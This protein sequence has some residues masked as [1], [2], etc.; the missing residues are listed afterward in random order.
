MVSGN[1]TFSAENEILYNIP[2]P[3]NL[4][5][6]R[7]YVEI[8]LI[9]RLAYC[10]N[11]TKET[12]GRVKNLAKVL[13]D[14]QDLSYILYFNH[15]S[16]T[17]PL[18]AAHMSQQIEPRQ[19]RRIVAPASFSHTDPDNPK[20]RVFSF[21]INEAKRC[22]IEITRVIQAYQVNNPEYEFSETQARTTYKTLMKQFKKA[23]NTGSVGCLISPEGHRSET[24]KLQ[25]VEKGL[26][27]IGKLLAPV[28]YVPLG[29]LYKG[30]C[31][32]DGLN[33][34][35]RISLSL[36][37]TVIQEKRNSTP[38]IDRLMQNLAETLPPEIR[39]PWG[40]NIS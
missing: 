14:R 5:R 16:Y 19:V 31:K 17:D 29:I 7:R 20:S 22:G 34:G 24:R 40:N 10:I 23:K 30:K 1:P 6:A 26:V 13:T 27:N 8:G 37:E 3:K 33:F 36:G 4:E 9:P 2:M 11:Q 32:R 28:V 12:K 39:G 38:T 15:V 25:T 35:R 18:F 21:I